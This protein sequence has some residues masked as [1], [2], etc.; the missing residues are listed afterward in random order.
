[1]KRNRTLIMSLALLIGVGGITYTAAGPDDR[2][3]R[4]ERREARDGERERGEGADRPA[5]GRIHAMFKGVDLTDE[6]KTT[7]RQIH[8]DRKDQMKEIRGE[9]RDAHEAKDREAMRAA[10][11]KLRA[12]LDE[13]HELIA[14][15]LTDEQREQF[16]ANVQEMRERMEERRERRAEGGEREGRRGGGDD[17]RP[18][19]GGARP[20]GPRD[21]NP[22]SDGGTDPH[23]LSAAACG[24][25]VLR[26]EDAPQVAALNTGIKTQRVEAHL[27]PPGHHRRHRPAGDVPPAERTVAGLARKLLRVDRPPLLRVDQR[28]VRVAADPAASPCRRARTAARG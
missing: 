18:R 12:Y 19:R 11:E 27:H 6:Q 26:R 24:R 3:E 16:E 4:G 5:R 15:E 7:L 20:G 22:P 2:P 28:D 23:P 1:M 10:G 25:V 13:T 14:A 21:A 17:D 9:M 8:E